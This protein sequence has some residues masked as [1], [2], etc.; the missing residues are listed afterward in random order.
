MVPSER[1]RGVNLSDAQPGVVRQV[2][3]QLFPC[4]FCLPMSLYLRGNMS[5]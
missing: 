4:R 1:R 2:L 3:P 5:Q